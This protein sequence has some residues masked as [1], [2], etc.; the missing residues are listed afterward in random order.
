MNIQERYL[1]LAREAA[2]NYFVGTLRPKPDFKEID[3]VI[4]VAAKV[5]MV[6]DSDYE[7]GSFANA[8][9]RNDLGRTITSADTICAKYIPF[10]VHCRELWYVPNLDLAALIK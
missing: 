7:G 3:H 2:D 4:S 6:R 9:V 1:N 8:V 5:M 10:F